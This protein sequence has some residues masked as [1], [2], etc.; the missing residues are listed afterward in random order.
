MDRDLWIGG[1]LLPLDENTFALSTMRSAIIERNAHPLSTRP[2]T[3]Y[4]TVVPQS[5][6][7]PIPYRGAP[8][9]YVLSW[10]AWS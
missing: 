4:R 10:T 3:P 5:V 1:I 8:I 9:S 2:N 6:Q 7:H